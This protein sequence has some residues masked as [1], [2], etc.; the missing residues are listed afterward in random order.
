MEHRRRFWHGKSRGSSFSQFPFDRSLSINLGH[1]VMHNPS[2]NSKKFKGKRG[3]QE[4]KEEGDADRT[5][6]KTR[7]AN[8]SSTT[9][10]SSSSFLVSR[11]GS[12]RK[13]TSSWCV[14][15]KASLS[16]LSPFFFIFLSFRQQH[17]KGG[18][19][20]YSLRKFAYLIWKL[21]IAL[22][23]ICIGTTR[24]NF[25]EYLVYEYTHYKSYH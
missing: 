4:R 21:P 13:K 19:S 12:K 17:C 11:K 23:D 9:A 3:E 24:A 15:K 20:V 7:R 22:F 14:R 16:L 5:N 6:A 2:F 18:K 1:K 8:F 10:H 25:A